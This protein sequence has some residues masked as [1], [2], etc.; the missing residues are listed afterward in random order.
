MFLGSL[1]VTEPNRYSSSF[2]RR[3]Q[4][5]FTKSPTEFDVCLI[6]FKSTKRFCQIF[7]AF[8]ENLNFIDKIDQ[9]IARANM[10]VAYYFKTAQVLRK[11]IFFQKM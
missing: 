10:F 5:L 9:N 4:F 7:E 1:P 11:N 8:V 6:K 3:P 2:L